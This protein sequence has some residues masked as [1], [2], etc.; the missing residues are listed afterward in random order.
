MD[1]SNNIEYKIRKSLRAKKMRIAVYC[2]GSVVVTVP[3]SFDYNLINKFVI[4]K[5][6]WILEKVQKFLKFPVRPVMPSSKRDFKKNKVEVKELIEKRIYFFNQ[7]YNYKYNK[8]NIKNQKTRWGSCSMKGNLNFN[9]RISLI[10]QKMA[11]YIVIHELCHLG[12]FNHSKKFW[13]LVQKAMP[14]YLDIR[15]EFRSE[16]YRL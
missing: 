9:Y 14:D 13:S 16:T 4:Q 12:E 3:N 10:P 2:D 15:K 6:D 1:I 8:I 11:D 7:F 5:K